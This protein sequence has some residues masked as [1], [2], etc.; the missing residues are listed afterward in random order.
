MNPAQ[1]PV[2][3]FRGV[4]P[5]VAEK[6]AAL[7]IRTAEDALF[8]L[9][10][11]YEDR[12]RFTPIGALRHG[13]EAL[14]QGEIELADIRF[15][16]R[17]SL[18]VQISDNTG[19]IILRF[20]HFSAAQKN[21]LRRGAR[22]SCYGEVRRGPQ[23][24]EMV[25]P[26]YT[27][28][29]LDEEPQ[30]EDTLT[31][32]YST[33]KGVHQ[34]TLRKLI[35]Q[36]LETSLDEL[37]DMLP[38]NVTEKY[39]FPRLA[40][41]I[42]LLHQPPPDVDTLAILNKKHPAQQRLAFEELMAHHLSLR[43]LREAQ[44]QQNAPKIHSDQRLLHALLT[45]LPF[46]LTGAQQRS[47][48]TVL[49]DL[50][51]GYP[52]SRLLQGDVGS[53][54]TIIAAGAA[55]GA[56]EAGYQVAIMAPTEIL[57]EQHFHSFDNWCK[58]LGVDVE[59]LSGSQTA[60][61]KRDTLERLK[62]DKPLITVGT[63]ALFQESVSF[64]RLGLLVI[65]E[66][67]RFGVHQRLALYEKGEGNG[68]KPH[69]LVMTAT[70]IPRSLAMTLYADLDLTVIDEL[71]PGRTP[72]TTV[73][74]P[75]TRR[76]DIIQRLRDACGEGRQ[77]YWV[78]PAIDESEFMEQL[79]AASETASLLQKELP[80]L[81]IGLIHGRLKP[82]EKEQVMTAFK[83]HEL[84]VLVATTVIEVGVDVPNASLMI[85]ENA[86]RLG[87]AQ[88]H[89]LRGRVGRGSA[90]SA[91]VLMYHG[92]LSRI[93]QDRLATMRDSNDGFRIAEKDLQLR[94]P[95]EVLGTRQTGLPDLRI[96]DLV[97]DQHLAP[98]VERA[99]SQLLE[100]YPQNVDRIIQR[101]LGEG[102]V[103]GQV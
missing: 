82:R 54:K 69:Q 15:G 55:L 42:A 102:Y 92:P 67:H 37:D 59:W 74:V 32:V 80:A 46:E 91:C 18:L 84:D 48:D 70:P 29:A 83:A 81:K 71:P 75:N 44:K 40:E 65:D 4:G 1:I 89:Q 33:T 47:L 57:A 26:E 93:A 76:D 79:Q 90:K 3:R 77:A 87:L 10:F 85:I 56:V 41:A 39:D 95:G 53:G 16:R 19:A 12:T 99:A 30:P 78:C 60:R 86:E 49:G 43:K 68:L 100:Q 7:N 25:H 38:A 34:L 24:L 5:K 31:P 63:H 20:F 94:G 28:F 14:I 36:A 22:I 101:W 103:F 64:T 61:Q 45:S 13:E 35:A 9:P 72:V 50:E 97:R 88:L 2:T 21:Q 23:T 17:R 98:L 51:L 6:L 27:L 11:R 62:L 8:H 96:A 73:V 52:M 66:Q 58:P